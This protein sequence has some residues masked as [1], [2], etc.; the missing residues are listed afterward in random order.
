MLVVIG[1]IDGY[2]TNAVNGQNENDHW[3]QFAKRNYKMRRRR[4]IRRSITQAAMNHNFARKTAMVIR[5]ITFEEEL[6]LK[7]TL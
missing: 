4:N 7:S 6:V 5:I 1:R 3:C 2:G